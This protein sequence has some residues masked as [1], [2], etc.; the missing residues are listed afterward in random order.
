MLLTLIWVGWRGVISPP[1]PPSG[2]PLITQIRLKLVTL[3]FCSIQKHIIRNIRPKFGIPNLPQTL[4]IGKNTDG[5]ISD[6]RISA[7]PLVTE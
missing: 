3:A 4:D 2:F 5:G 1:P 7:Q 6:F